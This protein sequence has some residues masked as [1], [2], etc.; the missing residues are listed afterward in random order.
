MTEDVAFDVGG[1]GRALTRKEAKAVTRARLLEGA[2]SI[3]DEEGEGALTTTKVTRLAGIAQ[4]SFYAHFSDMDDLLRSLV[5]ELA[6]ERL[7]HT[8]AARRAAWSAP[9]DADRLRDT[10]RI[11]IAYSAQH[12]RLFRLLLKSRHDRTS[13]LGE[14][15]RGVV[16][17]SRRA[18]VADLRSVAN[19][20]PSASELRQIEMMAD[21]LMAL[22]EAMVLG[23]LEGRFPDVEECVDV[24]MAFS[25]G[26]YP[27]LLGF[28]ALERPEG[29]QQARAL[30]RP[31]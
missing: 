28:G 11:P 14:W 22:T 31:S 1:A 10:F 27:L 30:G 5:E 15:S 29:Q 12:P 13:P 17:Q 24:L 9:D 3:L 18:L 25:R 23:H 21:G 19:L 8:R 26:Y 20:E 7:R 16:E 2:L 4:P 6:R